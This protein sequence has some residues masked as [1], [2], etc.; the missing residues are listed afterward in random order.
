MKWIKRGL[1][2][3]PSGDSWWAQ[4]WA[5]QPTPLLRPDGTIRVFVGLRTH[6]GI[7]RVGFVDVSA[8]NPAEVLRV[9]P[10][11]VLDIGEPGAFDENGVV[12]C[13]IVE[14]EGKLYLYYAGYQLGQKV[15]FFVFGGLAISE[16][17]GVSFRRHSRVPIC[18]RTDD[19]RF[20]R[21]IHSI[22]L[23]NGGWRVWYGAGSEFTYEN[24]RALPNYDIRYAESDD[25]ITLNRRAG[26]WRRSGARR[27]PR[28]SPV[29][30]QERRPLSDVFFGSDRR[31]RLSACLRGIQRRHRLDA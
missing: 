20:F 23:E 22:M 31:A 19:E 2:Y 28:R 7:S 24:G 14:R 15:K 27:V 8:D 4:R 13:A 26:T 30:C 1:I 5:L 3:G 12:P 6:E 16:D 21:V 25:G 9:S 11:P 17:G 18:D 10:E 29:R